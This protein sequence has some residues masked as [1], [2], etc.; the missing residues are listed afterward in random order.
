MSL[1]SAGDRGISGGAIKSRQDFAGGLFLLAIAG[2]AFAGAFDLP[3]GRLS[4][5]GSG[6]LPKTVAV[7]V[8]AFGVALVGLSLTSPGEH[9]ERWHLRG[10]IYVLG[11]VFVFALTIRGSTLS[12]AGWRVH[13][14]QLGLAIAGPLAMI[15]SAHADKDTRLIEIIP[16]AVVLTVLAVGLFKFLLRLPIPIFPLGYGPF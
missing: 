1:G 2:V 7:L 15:I 8:A 9:L 6:L 5:I 10:P 4:G 14:P 13:I 16:F 11:A 12:L 3:F